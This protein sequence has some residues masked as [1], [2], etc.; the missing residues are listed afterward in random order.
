MLEHAGSAVSWRFRPRP[1]AGTAALGRGTWL[2][3]PA[4]VLTECQLV[5]V[6]L[7][8]ALASAFTLQPMVYSGNARLSSPGI[9]LPERSEGIIS[10]SPTAGNGRHFL[11]VPKTPGKCLS[12]AAP[13]A[14]KRDGGACFQLRLAGAC[15]TLRR[16]ICNSLCTF[17]ATHYALFRDFRVAGCIAMQRTTHFSGIS[18]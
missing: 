13:R 15:R 17:P 14:Y 8:F 3:A 5:A 4:P 2:C 9:T 7:P 1:R 12:V 10:F 6:S 16:L 11:G 18:V